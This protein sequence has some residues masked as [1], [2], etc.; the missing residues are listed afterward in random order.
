MQD[1][2]SFL[3]KANEMEIYG[4][5]VL[6]AIVGFDRHC[7][8]HEEHDFQSPSIVP[9]EGVFILPEGEWTRL[10]SMPKTEKRNIFFVKVPAEI[11]V[12]NG[13]KA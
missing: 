11:G 6:Q 9:V 1:L 4:G 2:L 10:R 5:L 8:I 7:V 13:D 12:L 3:R